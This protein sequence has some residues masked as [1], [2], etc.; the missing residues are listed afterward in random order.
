MLNATPAIDFYIYNKNKAIN[1]HFQSLGRIQPAHF[2]NFSKSWF[3]WN[4]I[5]NLRKQLC[6]IVSLSWTFSLWGLLRILQTRLPLISAYLA[7]V[8]TSQASR[9]RLLG[10]VVSP[11]KVCSSYFKRSF[12]ITAFHFMISEYLIL[13]KSTEDKLGR[14]HFI[15]GHYCN[16]GY[17]SLTDTSC[18]ASG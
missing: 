4:R 1:V 13:V 12:F 17:V 11:R 6:K 5:K 14:K 2:S 18:I 3:M 15:I 8:H 9:A 16:T 10:L 7:L